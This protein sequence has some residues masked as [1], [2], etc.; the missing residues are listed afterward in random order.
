MPGFH[1]TKGST[2]LQFEILYAASASYARFEG[3]L[4]STTLDRF[5]T[6]GN[7]HVKSRILSKLYLP[8]RLSIVV[9]QFVHPMCCVYAVAEFVGILP[10]E[11]FK[12][13]SVHVS[14]PDPG[15]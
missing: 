15:Q 9:L 12:I 1:I 7:I 14:V 6:L 11:T 2:R 10:I 13:S 3:C 5:L 8:I 4:R